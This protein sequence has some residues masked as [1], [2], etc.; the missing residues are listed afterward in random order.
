[1]SEPVILVVEDEFLVSEA[2]RGTLEDIGY[3][4]ILIAQDGVAARRIAAA[5]RPDLVL[6]DITL[7]GSNDADDQDG[8]EVARAIRKE[9]GIPIVFVTARVD[10]DTLAR[11]REFQPSGY[12]TKPISEAQTRVTIDLALDDARVR[13]RR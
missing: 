3:R 10:D 8:I 4:N 6:M 13:T 9:L 11:A 7:R 5:N 1:M 2:I 12:I